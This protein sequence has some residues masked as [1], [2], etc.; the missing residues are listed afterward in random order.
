MAIIRK[1]RREI[2]LMRAAGRLVHEILTAI[3]EAVRPGTTT[4]ELDALAEEMIRRAGAEAL[5]KGQKTP[6]AKVPYPSVICTSVNE[7]VVH[8]IPGPRPLK[9]GEI[10]SVDV[11]VRL[12][13]YC[14]DAA[15]TFPVGKVAPPVRR[16]LD[17][18]E[19]ALQIAVESTRPGG[20]WSD[21]ARQMQQYVEGAGFSVVRDFVGHGI[22]REM[23]EDPKVPNFVDKHGRQGDIRLEPGLVL[24]VEPMVNMGTAKVM[25]APDGLGWAVVTRDGRWAAHFEHTLAVTEKGA[26]VLTDGR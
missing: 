16:L 11:G 7:E 14:G 21:V 5:F 12:A 15:T 24:A 20:R 8:G 23:H 19:H 18:T 26:D 2:E 3:A 25:Y 9:E 10:V 17:V 6:Q 4:R 22:G 13:G 1:S